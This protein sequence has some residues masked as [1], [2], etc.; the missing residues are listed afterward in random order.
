MRRAGPLVATVAVMVTAAAWSVD[1]VSGAVTRVVTATREL[2]ARE[3]A[4]HV[5]NRLAFGPRPGD[6]ERVVAMGVDRWIDQQL[7]PDGVPDRE[8]D[9]LVA[10]AFPAMR[11]S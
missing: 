9:R 4:H 1:S 11:Q 5:L 10:E 3:Q 8:A 2:T 6:V 7:R